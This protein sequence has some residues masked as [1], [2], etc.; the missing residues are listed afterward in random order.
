MTLNDCRISLRVNSKSLPICLQLINQEG[1]SDPLSTTLRWN[2]NLNVYLI[3][4]I[5][6]DT[7][8]NPLGVV[9]MSLS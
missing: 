4:S 8:K 7:L 2:R 5:L 6:R 3:D 1:N 9:S